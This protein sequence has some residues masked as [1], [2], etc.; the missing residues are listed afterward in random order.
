MTTMLRAEAV[1][2]TFVLHLQGGVVL[3][4]LDGVALEVGAGRCVALA[5][6]SGGPPTVSL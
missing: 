6:P 1:G 4:V 3:P 2:K 5:G